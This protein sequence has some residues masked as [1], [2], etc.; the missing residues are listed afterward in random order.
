MAESLVPWYAWKYSADRFEAS[1]IDTIADTIPNRLSLFTELFASERFLH[2][3]QQQ[4]NATSLKTDGQDG[5]SPHVLGG[6]QL[7]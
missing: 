7:V 4:L 6:A 5:G 1:T 2:G 3:I